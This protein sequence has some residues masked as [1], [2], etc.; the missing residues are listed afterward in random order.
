MCFNRQMVP[1]VYAKRPYL[2]EARKVFI[3]I[4]DR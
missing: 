1:P 4:I 3:R 2:A